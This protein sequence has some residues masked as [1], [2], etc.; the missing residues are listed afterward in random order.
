M[1]GAS[2]VFRVPIVEGSG[3]R[4]DVNDRCVRRVSGFDLRGLGFRVDVNDRCVY[5]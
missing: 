3:F 2:N 4:V 1:T 5:Q